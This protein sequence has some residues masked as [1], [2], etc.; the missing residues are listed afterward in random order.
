MYKVE[1]KG[2]PVRYKDKTYA[3]GDAFL[4]E[5]NHLNL[6]KDFVEV[7]EELEEDLEEDLEELEEAADLDKLKKSELQKLLEEKEIEYNK[8]ATKEEL[9]ELL[10]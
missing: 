10:K 4:I 9:L 5:E 8:N 1:V 3:A 6:M 7:K 2:I